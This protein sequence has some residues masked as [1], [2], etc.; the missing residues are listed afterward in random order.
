MP[1]A[2]TKASRVTAMRLPVKV[3][4]DIDDMVGKGNRSRFIIAAIEKELKRQKRLSYTKNSPGLII[5]DLVP[6]RKPEEDDTL[7][8]VN[9]LRAA[10]RAD[11][12]VK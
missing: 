6:D 1:T 5:G 4:K 12:K 7:A 8:F 9:K 2:S 10:D 3:L 11:R